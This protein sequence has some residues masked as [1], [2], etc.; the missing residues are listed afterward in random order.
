MSFLACGIRSDTLYTIESRPLDP[1]WSK[2]DQMV[3]LGWCANA[4][5]LGWN[6]D[7]AFQVAEAVVMSS[8]MGHIRWPSQQLNDDIRHLLETA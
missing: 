1:R 6:E 3:L 4:L 2:K 8:K 7:R 5:H